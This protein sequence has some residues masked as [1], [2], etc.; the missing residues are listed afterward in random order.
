MPNSKKKSSKKKTDWDIEMFERE[1]R[2]RSAWG[3]YAQTMNYI[4]VT[5]EEQE[6]QTAKY[7]KDEKKVK[8]IEDKRKNRSPMLYI[9]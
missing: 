5:E 9:G 4:R 2:Q 6:Y 8:E 3:Q 1:A 7:K